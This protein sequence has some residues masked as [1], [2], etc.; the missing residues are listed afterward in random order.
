MNDPIHRDVHRIA[1]RSHPVKG[2]VGEVARRVRVSGAASTPH[3]LAPELGEHTDEILTSL[4]YT[5]EEIAE[6]R[7]DRAIR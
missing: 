1:E 4:G 3:R 5:A 2:N 6:L 7:C